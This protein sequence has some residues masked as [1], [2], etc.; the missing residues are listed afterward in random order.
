M[1]SFSSADAGTLSSEKTPPPPS[2]MGESLKEIVFPEPRLSS[3]L[4]FNK[5]EV[6]IRVLGAKGSSPPSRCKENANIFFKT[7]SSLPR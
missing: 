5:I 7:L 6:S 4:I 1:V 3:P 2:P